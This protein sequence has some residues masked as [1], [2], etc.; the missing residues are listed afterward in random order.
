MALI[1]LGHDRSLCNFNGLTLVIEEVSTGQTCRTRGN[2]SGTAMPH[3][4]S[5]LL[6]LDLF[7]LFHCLQLVQQGLVADLQNLGSLP[8]IPSRLRQHAFDGFTLGLHGS[9]TSNFE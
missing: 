3:L 9:S 1:L 5:V 6:T 4:G 7:V 8:A 2:L